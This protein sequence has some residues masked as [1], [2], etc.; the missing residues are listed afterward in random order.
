MDLI[1]WYIYFGFLG[2]VGL[3]SVLYIG[4]TVFKGTVKR[5]WLWRQSRIQLYAQLRKEQVELVKE[6]ANKFDEMLREHECAPQW[7]DETILISPYSDP[8]W[9]AFKQGC[10]ASVTLILREAREASREEE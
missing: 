5:F 10:L 1:G 7:T 8:Y 6:L 4:H 3:G 9:E 2:L